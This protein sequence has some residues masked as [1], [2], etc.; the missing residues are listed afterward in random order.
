M[1]LWIWLAYVSDCIYLPLFA[2]RLHVGEER[3]RQIQEFIRILILVMNIYGSGF[4]HF[5]AHNKYMYIA[6]LSHNAILGVQ[7]IIG[8]YQELHH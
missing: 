2:L 1:L 3:V 6:V 4:I 5:T 7:Y 8:T